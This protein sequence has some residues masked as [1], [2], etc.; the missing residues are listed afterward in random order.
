M[1]HGVCGPLV[2]ILFG[3]FANKVRRSAQVEFQPNAKA[4]YQLI[5]HSK[6]RGPERVL[7]FTRL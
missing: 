1:G 2:R 4:R 5:V 3:R 7:M 6:H